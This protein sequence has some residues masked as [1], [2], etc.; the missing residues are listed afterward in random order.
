MKF[1]KNKNRNSL[2]LPLIFIL[3]VVQLF[4][5]V[6][7]SDISSASYGNFN[8]YSFMGMSYSTI[9]SMLLLAYCIINMFTK[10]KFSF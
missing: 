2:F 8:T 10:S 1:I 9:I 6:P 7:G 4:I 5:I 3:Y